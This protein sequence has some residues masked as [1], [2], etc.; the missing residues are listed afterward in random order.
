MYSPEE[1]E[2]IVHFD[3]VIS[4]RFLKGVCGMSG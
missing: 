4:P 1:Y 3:Y 2:T